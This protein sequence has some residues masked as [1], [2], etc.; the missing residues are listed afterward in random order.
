NGR[1]YLLE[2][3]AWVSDGQLHLNWTYDTQRYGADT[4]FYVANRYLRA[5]EHTIAHCVAIDQSA[6]VT[7][8]GFTPSD[9]PDVSFTQSELDGFIGQLKPS[10]GQ[11]SVEA[12][13][14][15]APLQQ[16]FL[17]HALQDS[18]QAGLLHMRGTL[19]GELDF[20]RLR[21]AWAQV[22]GRHLALRTSVHWQA[23][24][25]P[26]QVSTRQPALPWQQLDWRE[27]ENPQQ[28]LAEFLKADRALGFDFAQGPIMRLTL[29]RV[30]DRTT[31]MVWTCHH[32]MLDGWSGT[33]VVNQVLDA[34]EALSQ[35]QSLATG[36]VPNYQDYIHWLNKQDEDAAERFWRDRLKGFTAPTPLPVVLESPAHEADR[37]G[38]RAL[39]VELLSLA[40]SVEE[41]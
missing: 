15:L 16:A 19:H 12:I 26:V 9:F 29:I 35:G 31:E 28:A 38:G 13:Y 11:D 8:G 30:G 22:V 39:P 1:S 23:L 6:S 32:L 5:L 17:W 14:P 4:I 40:L 7:R 37:E 36:R 21:Q 20:A 10:L 27:R 34:Y 24:Q 3:N 25:Q 2:I 18:S 33:L 41:T